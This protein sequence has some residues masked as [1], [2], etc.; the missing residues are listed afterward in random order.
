MP[1]IKVGFP[2]KAKAGEQIDRLKSPVK[3]RIY[4]CKHCNQYHTTRQGEK[5]EAA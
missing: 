5:E 3:M 4:L 1:C 2:S